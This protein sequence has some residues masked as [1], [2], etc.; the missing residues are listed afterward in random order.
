MFSTM[1]TMRPPTIAP[2]MESR[3]PRMTTGNTLKPTR[4]RFTSTPMMFPQMMPP[5]AE[6][7]P[8]IAHA[9]PKYRSTLMPMAMATCWLSA[10]A[11]MA[12][13]LRD[14][15][16]NQPKPARNSKLTRPPTSWMGGMN[17]GPS[18][19]GSSG[20]GRGKGRDPAPNVVGP[21]PRRMAARPIVAMTTAMTGRP[22]SLRSITR[23]RAKPK[24]IMVARPSAIDTHSGA[25]QMSRAAAT[26]MPAII[27]NS[28]WAKL[29]ASVALYTST[30]PS[31]MSAYMSPM[32]IPLDI[33]SRKKPKSSDTSGGSL[34]VL[35]PDARL[36][37]GLPAVLVR[38]RRRQLDLVLAAVERA[39]HLRILVG[40]VEAPHFPGARHL[41]VVGLQVLGEQQE[42]TDP[43]RLRQCLVRLRDLLADQLSRLRLLRHVHVGGVRE[44]PAL[45]PVA[46]GA[47]VDGDHR[48]H[49]G[50][51]IAE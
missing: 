7:M 42:A 32:R 30:K 44:A 2:G 15:T 10:T 48:R 40:H 50:P 12:M 45:G 34:H 29:T 8:V 51:V 4:A 23:S 9:R 25:F 47:E 27:T 26:R 33:K 24:A 38:D 22:I 1:P 31:A 35:D 11:R 6:T 5:S 13:P 41:R 19:M 3:P 39:D 14:F 37:G 16:K 17:R 43:R 21:I 28:P 36:D 20:I 49:E 46:H 18:T